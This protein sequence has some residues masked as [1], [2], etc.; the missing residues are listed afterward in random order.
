MKG[1]RSLWARAG[2]SL[3]GLR[4][5]WRRERSFRDLVA[6]GAAA[7]LALAVVGARGFEWAVVILAWTLALGL[8]MMNGAL[9]AIADRIHPEQHR[10]IGAAKDMA[11]GAVFIANCALAGLTLWVIARHVF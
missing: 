1:K 7:L 8:E 2:F 4:E 10:D 11:S 3:A 9:E 5:A 6:G